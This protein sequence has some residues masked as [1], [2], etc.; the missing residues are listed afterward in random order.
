MIYRIIRPNPDWQNGVKLQMFNALIKKIR[1]ARGAT[2]SFS[3]SGLYWE[4]RYASGGNSGKGSYGPFAEF[5]AQVLNDFV[6]ANRIEDVI[7][8]GCGDGN[9]LLLARYPSYAGFDV[10]TTSVECCSTLF[11]HD[12]SKMFRLV[13]DYAGEKAS[14]SLSLDVIYHL[15]EDSVFEEYMNRLFGAAK[16]FVI[17]Y[18]SNRDEH[19][20]PHVRHRRFTPWVRVHQ[21]EFELVDV[22]ENEVSA[23]AG[24]SG[25]R[26]LWSPS[27]F[28]IY[29]RRVPVEALA[30]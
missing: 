4:S 13:D 9:Q 14:L 30:P 25:D 16:K 1:G 29:S 10:S 15:V 21:P 2:T 22:I 12:S 23:Q 18:S 26:T 5:K 24:K 7:E 6:A 17:I 28:Y 3:G 8:F 19:G 20:A 27:T 11:S